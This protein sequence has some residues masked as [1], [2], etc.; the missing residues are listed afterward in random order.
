MPCRFPI[1]PRISPGTFIRLQRQARRLTVED[2]ALLIATSPGVA[3]P[4]RAEWLRAIEADCAPISLPTAW[5][6]HD[7]IGLDLRALSYWM[8]I[9]EGARPAPVIVDVVAGPGDVA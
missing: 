8:A 3:A 6:L 7:A 2:V 1:A 9:A 5:A 4:R